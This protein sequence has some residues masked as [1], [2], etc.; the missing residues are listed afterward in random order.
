MWEEWWWWQP[1]RSQQCREECLGIFCT[2]SSS[3]WR[4]SPWRYQWSP[5]VCPRWSLGQW[6]WC[7]SWRW[8]WVQMWMETNSLKLSCDLQ[9]PKSCNFL[10]ARAL[11]TFRFFFTWWWPNSNFLYYLPLSV[12]VWITSSASS[13]SSKTTSSSLVGAALSK[14][15]QGWILDIVEKWKL[16]FLLFFSRSESELKIINID[17]K[18][19]LGRV[20]DNDHHC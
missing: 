19:L 20:L 6:G 13:K 3:P 2:S 18:R 8:H 11:G 14:V 10:F 17:I 1:G 4:W 7:W 12:F 15:L 9:E 16:K 5:C